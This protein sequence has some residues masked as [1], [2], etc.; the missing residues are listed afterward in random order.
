MRCP[1][2]LSALLPSCDTLGGRVRRSLS[3]S[4]YAS[5]SMQSGLFVACNVRAVSEAIISLTLT[6]PRST[7][8]EWL[9][10]RP[11]MHSSM[12]LCVLRSLESGLAYWAA[13]FGSAEALQELLDRRPNLE[14]KDLCGNTA[15]HLAAAAGHL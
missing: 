9:A 10:W 15:L 1:A 7:T 2:L 5:G 3:A 14:A 4:I 8:A 13:Y 6:A 11:I 12:I